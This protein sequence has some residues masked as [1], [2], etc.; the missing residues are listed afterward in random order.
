VGNLL[1]IKTNFNFQGYKA[2]GGDKTK[3]REV[4]KDDDYQTMME[5]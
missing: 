3:L 5:T 4:P 2:T 1:E